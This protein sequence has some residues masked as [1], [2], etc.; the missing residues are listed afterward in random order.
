MDGWEWFCTLERDGTFTGLDKA[1][2]VVGHAENPPGFSVEDFPALR[3]G[4]G[5]GGR[6]E[7][8]E[9]HCSPVHCVESI[10]A[11][12]FQRR[13]G[14]AGLRNPGSHLRIPMA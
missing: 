1:D 4:L 12:V 11:N 3:L 2:G 5:L 13:T 7:W 9:L 8:A 10:A 14:L 6:A